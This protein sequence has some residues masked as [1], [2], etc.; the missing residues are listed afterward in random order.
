VRALL[1]SLALCCCAA[2][3]PSWSDVSR[4]LAP[5]PQGP[6]TESHDVRRAWWDRAATRPKSET[7]WLLARDGTALKDGVERRW[8]ESG[9]LEYERHWTRD[10]PSGLWRAWFEDGTQRF[11]HLYDP[12]RA[13][14]MT[15]WHATGA[16][17]SAG[18]AREGVREGPWRGDHPDGA[19]AFEGAFV[20]NRRH[21]FWTFWHPDGSLET[22]GHYQNGE[23][24]GVWESYAPGERPAD[25]AL[26]RAALPTPS[27][28]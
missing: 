24:I 21:G 2:C 18:P 16:V 20:A 7:G 1:A 12:G 8:Y 14:T 5:P 3:G 11:E 28:P 19:R 10:R 25:A 23:R 13:T 15:W 6:A 27:D 9:E 17:S 22:S 26:E 4:G